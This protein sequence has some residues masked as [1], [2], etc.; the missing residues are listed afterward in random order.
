MC[1]SRLRVPK[2]ALH[3]IGGHQSWKKRE[4]VGLKHSRALDK[5]FSGGTPEEMPV[6]QLVRMFSFHWWIKL[7]YLSLKVA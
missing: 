7:P 2:H 3:I 6:V 4:C 5:S 1:A